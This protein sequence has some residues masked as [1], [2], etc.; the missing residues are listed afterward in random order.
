MARK[1]YIIALEEHYQDPEV[2]QLGGGPGAGRDVVERLDDLGEHPTHL[3]R[4]NA[5]RHGLS[6][7]S[8]ANII[9]APC[10]HLSKATSEPP[11]NAPGISPAGTATSTG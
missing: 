5:P 4:M 2:K 3:A 7:T 10:A 9:R 11:M 8:R 6:Q 1:P